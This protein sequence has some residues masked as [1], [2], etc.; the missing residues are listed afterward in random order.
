MAADTCVLFKGARG[1]ELRREVTQELRVNMD[2][3]S[4]S[5]AVSLRGPGAAVQRAVA[6]LQ[7]FAA[8]P[9]VIELPVHGE[10]E[11]ALAAGGAQ[12]WGVLA[13]QEEGVG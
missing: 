8:R 2:I 9:F 7:E 5:G 1:Q 11:S 10:D 3:D 12:G 4:E 13:A 6:P